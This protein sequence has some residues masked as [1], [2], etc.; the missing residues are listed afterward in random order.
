VLTSC[1][2]LHSRIS[3]SFIIIIQLDIYILLCTAQQHIG[4]LAALRAMLDNNKDFFQN[5][6]DIQIYL[7]IQQ[8][9]RMYELLCQ[10]YHIYIK[11]CWI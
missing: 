5:L 3:K 6:L 7:N 4:Q 1:C 9:G 2:A 11:Q 8:H 10:I